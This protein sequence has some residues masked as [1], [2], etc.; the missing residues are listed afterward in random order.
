MARGGAV[1]VNTILL[2][3][4]VFRVGWQR[5]Q[6]IRVRQKRSGYLWKKKGTVHGTRDV[7][8]Q[9]TIKE[10]REKGIMVRDRTRKAE[11]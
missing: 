2:S 11:T 5:K 6:E 8:R 3:W 7:Q 10:T 1:A 9:N 4:V